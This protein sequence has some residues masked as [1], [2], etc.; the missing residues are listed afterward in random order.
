MRSKAQ[1]KGHPLHPM[2]VAFP[3]A[4]LFGSFLFDL[5]G[6][7]GD[8]PSA[9]TTGAYLSLA[10][11]AT[12][13][14]AGIPGLVDYLLAVPPN[15][16]GKKRATT[17]MIVNV[18]ALACFAVAWAFRE[19][20][21][22]MP[23]TGTLVLEGL[24]LVL[25]TWGGWMGG[26]LVYRNQIGIDHRYAGAG[27]WREQSVEGRPGESL[28]VAKSDE[29]AVGQMKLIHAGGR[30]LVLARTD[31]GHVVFDDHCTHCGGSLADGVLACDTVTCPWHGSQ[32]NVRTGQVK[33]GRAEQ[34]I[35]TY[36]VT[37]SG[38]EVRL[39]LP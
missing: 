33:S 7:L 23:G 30:R 24:G 27:K 31:D 5:A 36:R 17:H 4:F 35:H 12:G 13:L 26:T 11:L 10:A 34:P 14:L 22:W 21:T 8:W 1:V 19:R 16:S 3:I 18:S 25:I 15:S 9:W 29:L 37:E 28:V 32:F 39:A 2:L 38:G 6:R 20:A